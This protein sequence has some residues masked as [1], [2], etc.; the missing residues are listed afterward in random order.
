MN[1]LKELP[2]IGE[3]Y[4]CFDD[5]KI[6]ESRRYTVTIK[7]IVPFKKIDKE[8]LKE[9][10]EEVK[11]CYWLYDNETDYFIKT[12]GGYD[13]EIF[14]RTKDGGWFSIIGGSAR[15]DI[16]GSLMESIQWK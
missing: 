7:E 8:T 2:K 9:W 1:T 14:V 12:E 16:D 3:I 5:G 6:K 10:K 4:N 15:L 13:N 11:T